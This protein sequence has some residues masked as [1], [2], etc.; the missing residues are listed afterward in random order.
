ML[1]PPL[2]RTFLAVAQCRSFTAASQLLALQQSTVSQ[3][4]RRLEKALGGLL[5]V[6]DT[7]SVVLTPEGEAMIGFAESILDTADRA[8][9][10]FAGTRARAKLRFGA[11]E[12]LVASWLPQ[13]LRDFVRIY[14]A[15]DFELTVALSATLV[16]RLDAGELDLVF[17]KRWPGNDRGELVWRDRLVWSGAANGLVTSLD[18]VPLVVYPPPS[19]TR[20]MALEALERVKR[21]WRITCTSSTLT[22]LTAAAAAGLG[23]VPHA[24]RLLP[25]SL[26]A[27]APQTD[28]PAL[29]DLEF[30]L[31]RGHQAVRG[32]AADL[33]AVISA[34]AAHLR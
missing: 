1:D 14:T 33:A 18:P 28:L 31:I 13:V 10:H 5:F 15:I 2:L 11:S 6:R 7:H 21:R 24:E 16:D 34:A 27:L 23:I 17:C 22:G 4:I 25:A 12:D 8:R 3:H 9:A 32:P 19:L 26:V 30:V 29:G 20:I